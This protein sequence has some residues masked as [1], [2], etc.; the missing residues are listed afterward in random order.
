MR[1]GAVPCWHVG[2]R[3]SGYLLGQA[4][5]RLRAS[6][7]ANGH[8][9][10]FGGSKEE[11]KEG[12]AYA[13]CRFRVPLSNSFHD[14]TLLICDISNPI[15]LAR[16]DNQMRIPLVY[17]AKQL[18]LFIDGE[19]G[20]VFPG[21]RFALSDAFLAVDCGIGFGEQLVHLRFLDIFWAGRCGG[22]GGT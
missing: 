17:F 21:A 19:F 3:S 2:L 8:V 6:F 20:G 11:G 16:R 1:G 22:R 12:T 5:W 18:V 7:S 14:T 10:Q 9:S 4:C 13:I 15:I